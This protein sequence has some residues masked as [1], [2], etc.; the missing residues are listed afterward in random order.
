[1][2]K[3]PTI[4]LIGAGYASKSL[5]NDNFTA[6]QEAFDNTVS[7]DGST[8]NAMQGDL[9]MNSNAILNV[10]T[11]DVDSLTVNGQLVNDPASLFNYRDAWVTATVYAAYDVVTE[12]G[13]SYVCL[14]NHTAGTFA[15]DLAANKWG[16][17][18][19][20]GASGAGSG[21]LISTNNL[22]DVSN[23]TTART[24]LGAQA[25]GDIL[26]DISGL[27]QATNKI[28][29][30]DSATTA[31]TLD[32]KDEDTMASDSATAVPSQQS[33]KAYVDTE[34]TTNANY[35]DYSAGYTSLSRSSGTAY[36]NT[37][38]TTIIIYYE[39]K[40]NVAAIGE[41]SPDNVTYYTI[42]GNGG[43][44]GATG[45]LIVPPGHYYK[46][47]SSAGIPVCVQLG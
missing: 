20:V 21:D 8:P 27:T 33:V 1:M 44:S 35:I 5:L 26:D 22:S 7:L 38:S 39:M 23:I 6:I 16:L 47:T 14:V 2:A 24:N 40:Y 15:T 3:R 25:Q 42:H 37:K 45:T 18:A 41:V 19:S 31:S 17:L 34:I 30:F 28:P 4:N 10:G 43:G 13:S 32:F 29:Y 46:I 12:N 36:Q 11:F 9:D